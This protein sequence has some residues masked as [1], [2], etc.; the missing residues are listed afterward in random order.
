MKTL[1]DLEY[2]RL[3]KG[4]MNAVTGGY[5]CY[6]IWEEGD[7][8]LMIVKDEKGDAKKS[9]RSAAEVI[10]RYFSN[11]RVLLIPSLPDLGKR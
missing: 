3:G 11:Y 6:A 8:P 1:K 7:E 4:Q 9:T 10:R 2:F 5:N